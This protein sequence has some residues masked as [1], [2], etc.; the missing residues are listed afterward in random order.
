MKY[1]ETPLGE[2]AFLLLFWKGG[3]VFIFGAPTNP[4]SLFCCSV[5]SQLNAWDQFMQNGELTRAMKVNPSASLSTIGSTQT[6]FR[7]CYR[8]GWH[9]ND[10]KGERICPHYCKLSAIRHMLSKTRL[11]KLARLFHSH[12][13]KRIH[14]AH[15]GQNCCPSL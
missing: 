5:D 10:T 1:G 3:R 2:R 8:T 13:G 4:C 7:T 6:G 12:I 9:W 11:K 15:I 14:W